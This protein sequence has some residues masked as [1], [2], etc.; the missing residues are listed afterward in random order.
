MGLVSLGIVKAESQ[1]SLPLSLFFKDVDHVIHLI[2][3]IFMLEITIVIGIRF[4]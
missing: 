2:G 3:E 1:D 4:K